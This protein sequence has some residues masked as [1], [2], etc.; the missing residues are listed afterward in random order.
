[1]NIWEGVDPG[2]E[3]RRFAELWSVEGPVLVDGAG[4]L[5]ERLGVRG[6]PTNIFVDADGTVTEVGAMT[7]ADLESAAR[8]LLGPDA[9]IDPP[10]TATGWH[11]GQD[12]AHIEKHI[13][14]H[15]DRPAGPR[16]GE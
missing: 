14:G 15:S 4:T 10:S 8:R 12:P 6:V 13:T 9:D 7:A 5:A 16:P 1:V 3:A 11:W 2:A